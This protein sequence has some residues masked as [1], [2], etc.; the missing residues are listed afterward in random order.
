MVSTDR[1][2]QTLLDAERCF[3]AMK[4]VSGFQSA[5]RNCFPAS[6]LHSVGRSA[7]HRAKGPQPSLNLE[8]P[9]G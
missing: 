4:N 5:G 6:A 8:V 9:R 1:L 2:L 7:L 3:K